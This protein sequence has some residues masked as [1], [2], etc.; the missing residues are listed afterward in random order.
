MTAKLS[1]ML[2]LAIVA[3][4]LCADEKTS[5]HK[6]ISA[7]PMWK[8]SG[9]LI[10][11]CSCN[12][13]C[14]CWFGSMPTRMTCSGDQ[15]IFIRSGSYNGVPLAG[16]AL[17]QF[18]RSPEGKT[19]MESFGNWDFDY[20]YIDDHASTE[21]RK[22]LVEVAKHVF[23]PAAK[24]RTI[25]YVP[26]ARKMQGK[27][28]IV[29]VGDISTASGHLI[30]GGYA[31]APKVVNPPMADPTHRSYQQGVATKLTFT[32]AGQDWDFTGTNFMINDFTVDNVEYEKFEAA[33]MK[34][35]KEMGKG[36]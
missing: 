31:G 13:A 23:P 7:K 26:I 15:V 16:L 22:A 12:A 21:Q 35:M 9:Q 10:E 2:G 29:H 4:G 8:I 36:G 11:A 33:M 25:K 34:K 14:P 32:D 30:D 17:A 24:N 20:V 1:V 6:P 5:N 3:V 27:E 18:V 28:F 19:M